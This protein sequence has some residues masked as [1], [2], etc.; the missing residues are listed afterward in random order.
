MSLMKIAIMVICKWQAGQLSTTA[1]GKMVFG[2]STVNRQSP[3]WFIDLICN[4]CDR[5][6]NKHYGNE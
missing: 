5:L 3:V 4:S 1:G 2:T 6:H